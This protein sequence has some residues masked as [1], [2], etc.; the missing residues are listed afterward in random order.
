MVIEREREIL[1]GSEMEIEI[2]LQRLQRGWYGLGGEGA[3]C[4]FGGNLFLHRRNPSSLI[5][6]FCKN[7]L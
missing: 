4:N 1:R 2:V 6:S 3:L 7:R 5:F